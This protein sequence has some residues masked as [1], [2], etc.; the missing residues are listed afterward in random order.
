MHKVQNLFLAAVLLA[1][2]GLTACGGQVPETENPDPAAA[3]QSASTPAP[4]ETEAPAPENPELAEPKPETEPTAEPAPTEAEVSAPAQSSA[5]QVDLDLTPLQPNMLY[6]EVYNM[7]ERPE[8]YQGKTIRLSGVFQIE[9]AYDDNFEV[10]PGKK[11][12][13]CRVSDA[14]GCCS[15][16]VEFRPQTGESI[17]TNYPAEET[18]IVV[19]GT[20]EIGSDDT[21]FIT[22]IR[23]NEATV[24]LAS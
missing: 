23:L 22:V 11:A 1:C 20:C 13:Y 14:M 7:E 12:L 16:G 10:I 21:G 15:I 24:E 6:A 9:E 17:L 4:A 8:E 5:G 19:T 3:Q 18:P 2:V